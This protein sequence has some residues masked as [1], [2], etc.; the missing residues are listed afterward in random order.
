M[1]TRVRDGG[2]EI[3]IDDSGLD[4]RA[5]IFDVDIEDAIHA[6]K[7]GEDAT[8]AGQRTAGKTSAG[9]PANERS[10]ILIG[11]LHDALH[12]R[13]GAREDDAGGARDFHGTVVFV[14]Q[15]FFGTMQ[16]GSIAEQRLKIAEEFG[17][18]APGATK[19]ESH[20]RRQY[21]GPSRRPSTSATSLRSDSCD[22]PTVYASQSEQLV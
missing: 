18:H 12:V 3:G 5:L 13:G 14:K 19:C 20:A 22:K 9:A 17:F 2:A 16:D 7:N 21:R 11:E 8:V 6:R 10:L 4:G 1:Q 15:Q